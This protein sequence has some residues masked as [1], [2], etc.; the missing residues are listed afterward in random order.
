MRFEFDDNGYVSCV[1]YGCS[2][3]SC[4][5]YN[6]LV[7]SQP[8]A[9]EDMDDW[10]DR[11]K[12]QAYYLNAQG[13][14]TYDAARAAALPDENEITPYSPEYL[15]KLGVLDAIYPVG[16]IYMSVHDVSPALLFGGTWERIE[17][18]FLLAA[19]SSHDAGEEGG[20]ESVTISID[21]HKHTIDTYDNVKF[22]SGAVTSGSYDIPITGTT[23][24]AG[25]TSETISTM[26]PYVTVYVWQRVEDVDYVSFLDSAGDTVTD[27]NSNEVM[28]ASVNGTGIAYQSKHTGEEIDAGIDAANKALKEIQNISLTPGADGKS[29][30]ELA[31]ENGYEGNETEW[32]ASL[33]GM[34]G[35]DGSDGK[36]GY[37]PVK[38]I[39]YF[40]GVDGKD[41]KDGYTPVKG[42]DYFDGADGTNGKDGKSAY[43]YAQE[44]GY[45]KSEAEFAEDLANVGNGGGG[46][47]DSVAW[48]NVTDKPFGNPTTSGVV[49]DGDT[50]IWDGN[51]DTAPINLNGW[52]YV[53]DNVPTMEQLGAGYVIF[54][55]RTDGVENVIHITPVENEDVIYFANS[56]SVYM[57]IVKRPHD[58]WEHAGV[59]FYRR[60]TYYG[61]VS[62]FQINNYAW[63]ETTELTKIPE[64]Y[65]PSRILS[66]RGVINVT[67]A[68]V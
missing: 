44:A 51:F 41:G 22:V 56:D 33:H 67:I 62:R 3:G 48:K 55:K 47:A 23:K 52:C 63:A 16:S 50:L 53:S 6:G 60:T 24:N 1:L 54:W 45:T 32:L 68:E 43:T 12:V 64:A 28:V 18:R 61:Y 2:T 38:G 13:N 46:T 37:T 8:E 31:L 39:D 35:K 30:Y 59:Y 58:S 36:D 26:P 25:G 66:L 5:E 27:A 10:A 14:L 57:C 21:A 40:D 19:G 65:I 20:A 29:A 42:V 34:D 49:I 17:D 15:Q 11:A 9:Y 4:V 7:P